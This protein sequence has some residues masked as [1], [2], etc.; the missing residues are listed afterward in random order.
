MRTELV[1]LEDLEGARWRLALVTEARGTLPADQPLG[2]CVVLERL[3]PAHVAHAAVDWVRLEDVTCDPAEVGV[4]WRDRGVM[5]LAT[6][7]ARDVLIQRMAMRG[8]VPRPTRLKVDEPPPVIAEP[9]LEGHFRMTLLEYAVIVEG[10]AAHATP[11][12]WRRADGDGR[13]L[14]AILDAVV[15]GGPSDPV[16]ESMSTEDM[17]HVIT[18]QPLA[19]AAMARKLREAHFLIQDLLGGMLS[20][21]GELDHLSEPPNRPTNYA[22]R[23]EMFDHWLTS[24]RERASAF[25]MI[26]IPDYSRTE[27]LVSQAPD[28]TD[29]P[30]AE[31]VLIARHEAFRQGTLGGHDYLPKTR[32]EADAFQPHTWVLWAMAAAI[33]AARRAP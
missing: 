16:A 20:L 18:A 10:N 15:T 30:T 22:K 3:A 2:A 4:D 23:V 14:G 5:F 9:D 1:R 13:S 7:V 27:P 25:S 28:P 8:M 33:A 17:M 24:A 11:G 21:R 29:L 26:Q 31:L 19:A 12:I 32:E 6:E